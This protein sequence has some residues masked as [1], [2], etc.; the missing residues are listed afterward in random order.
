M[1]K[2]TT[3]AENIRMAAK[4]TQNAQGRPLKIRELAAMTGFSYEHIRKLWMGKHDGQRFSLSR[5]CNDLL[6]EALGLNKDAMWTLAEQEKFSQKAGYIPVQ[7]V[8]DPEGRELTSFWYE[9]SSEQHQ[10][11]LQMARALRAA[12]Q[13]PAHAMR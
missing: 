6:C 4:T 7:L 5:E 10:M 12:S 8:D 9:L 11:I 13:M 2:F 1:L 3:Y